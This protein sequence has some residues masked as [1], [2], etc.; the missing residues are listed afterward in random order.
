MAPKRQPP[1][2]P[3]HPVVFIKAASN[4]THTPPAPDAVCGALKPLIT[5]EKTGGAYNVSARFNLQINPDPL[6]HK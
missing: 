2:K 3:D 4:F 1:P 5:V 6:F